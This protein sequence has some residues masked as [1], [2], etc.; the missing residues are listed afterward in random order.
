VKPTENDELV[1]VSV[2][3]TDVVGFPI[4]RGSGIVK[5][6]SIKENEGYRIGLIVLNEKWVNSKKKKMSRGIVSSEGTVQ[7]ENRRRAT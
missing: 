4:G 6:R 7:N 5:E 2:A 3:K 1:S